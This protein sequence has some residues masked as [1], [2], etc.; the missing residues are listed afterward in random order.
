MSRPVEGNALNDGQ[1]AVTAL[2]QLLVNQGGADV[3]IV[4]SNHFV[5]YAVLPPSS[6]LNSDAERLALARIVFTRQYGSLS[7]DWEIR[8][9]PAGKQE[10]SLACALPK[11]LLAAVAKTVTAPLRLRSVRPILMNVF[12]ATRRTFNKDESCLII[13]ESG[14]LTLG[15]MRDGQWRKVAS[16]A[17][18][19]D[20]ADALA[21]LFRQGALLED[22][23]NGADN[24]GGGIAWLCDLN[25]KH[26]I[27]ATLP[28]PLRFLDTPR[29]HDGSPPRLVG[30]SSP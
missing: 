28:W 4:L 19:P 15:W 12:N 2:A 30:W 23:G 11:S 27:N 22:S 17:T 13:A 7:Q 26:H 14:R 9:T 29:R 21:T 16:R 3:D 24:R 18:A 8:V 1:A 5:Q 25:G 10:P 20:D 6:G